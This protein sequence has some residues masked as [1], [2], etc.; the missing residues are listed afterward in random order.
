[1]DRGRRPRGVGR[2]VVEL[3]A[4]DLGMERR[5]EARARRRRRLARGGARGSLESDPRKAAWMGGRR[6]TARKGFADAFGARGME[7]HAVRAHVR[8]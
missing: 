5:C 6:G 2:E 4:V 8:G 1:V 3:G 7:G